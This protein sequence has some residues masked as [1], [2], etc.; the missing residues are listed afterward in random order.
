MTEKPTGFDHHGLITMKKT[1]AALGISMLAS[2]LA[3]VAGR[4]PFMESFALKSLDAQFRAY[5][6]PA[7]ADKRIILVEVD[8]H[9]LD[10]FERDNIPFPWPRSLYNPIIEYCAK[11]GARAV[12]FDILFNNISPY[13][14]ETDEQ[15]A[16]AMQKAGNVFLAA[17]FTT[18]GSASGEVMKA[19]QKSG[20]G[21]E[22]AA[23]M[24]L[25]KNGASLPLP[26]L[27]AAARG[28]ASVTFRPDNDGVYRRV[29][30]AIVFNGGLIPA[31]FAAPVFSSEKTARFDNRALAVNGLDIPLDG[32]GRMWIYYHGGRNA[33][34]RYSAAGVISSA[35]AASQG[36]E[37]AIAPEVFND[38]YVIIGYTAPGLF[39]LKPTPLSAVSPG[40]EIH[41]AALDNLLNAR[42]LREAPLWLTALAAL[43]GA[44]FIAFSVV[45][46]NSVYWAGAI[47]SLT[48]GALFATSGAFFK[49]GQWMS[50]LTLFTSATVSLILAAGYKY[51]VEGRQRRFI[52]RAFQHYVSPSVVSQIIKEPERLQLGGEKREITVLFSDLVGFTTLSERLEASALV[53]I[54]NG[55]TTLM[56]ETITQR[57]GTVDKYIG[58]AVM[59][60]WGA[61]VEQERHAELACLSALECL[62]RLDRFR[63]QLAK[64]GLPEINMRVGL[65]SGLC[66]V[67]NMGSRDRFDYTAIGDAVNQSSRLEGLNK[68]YN[69]RILAAEVT[70]LAAQPVVFG[71]KIDLLVVKGKEKPTLVYE[72]M[73]RRGEE[74]GAM[75]EQAAMYEEAF[76][77]YSNRDW[78]GAVAMCKTLIERYDDLPSKTLLER[79]EHY[80]RTP[81][82][83][84]WDGAFRHTSK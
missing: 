22:G 17:A 43:A 59:A 44:L 62:A 30:P 49:S 77:R 53:G 20:I 4:A 11:N 80:M 79:A 69:T 41:A 5:A 1:A 64:Q 46:I 67:G 21:F 37:P 3:V 57:D 25:V 15:F 68:A 27:A 83:P 31:L 18:G 2:I 13:G 71:R 52:Q 73:A 78:S 8:Q 36:V 63:A 58:D 75:V 38:A 48:L 23:P 35:L 7:L 28:L 51:Q 6:N 54:L 16:G 14:E 56:A 45:F 42:F 32:D 40:M 70:Y 72:I 10:H 74:T 19:T 34:K 84:E 47:T 50:L 60:F 65:N 9:S 82:P 33:Y 81:P 26:Q 55:Y 76:E 66:V 12:M 29:P 39:D 24:A 61:P